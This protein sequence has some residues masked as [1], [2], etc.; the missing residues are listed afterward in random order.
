MSSDNSL[1]SG[2]YVIH[3]VEDPKNDERLIMIVDP[4]GSGDPVKTEKDKMYKAADQDFFAVTEKVTQLSSVTSIYFEGDPEGK[5]LPRFGLSTDF[6]WDQLWKGIDDLNANAQGA[7]FYKL[8]FFGR[9]GHNEH[10]LKKAL[11]KKYR[12]G[13]GDKTGPVPVNYYD[14]FDAALSQKGCI[15]AALV[16]NV[17]DSARTEDPVGIGLPQL[18]FCSPMRRALT[19]N[20]ITFSRELSIE[21]PPTPKMITLVVENCRER[22]YTD[23]SENRHPK[24]WISEMFSNYQIED[25]F[26]ESDELWNPDLEETFPH[27]RARARNVLD[28]IFAPENTLVKCT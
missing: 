22:M 27:F 2:T 5:L 1:P 25:S 19:T 16:R 17:W 28:R 20:T 3:N 6:T 14:G 15:Q 21:D 10:D 23:N 24:G 13:T 8:I 9:H 12:Q 18:S 26:T 7:T 11:T 4:D